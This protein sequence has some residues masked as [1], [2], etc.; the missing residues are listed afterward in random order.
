MFTKRLIQALRAIRDSTGDLAVVI[1]GASVVMAIRVGG[2]ALTYL[3]HV[4]IARWAGPFEFGIFA[5]AWVWATVL[6]FLAPLGLNVGAVRFIPDYLAH[7]RWSLVAGMIRRS[8]SLVSGSGLILSGLAC[9]TVFLS[10]EW[11][12]EYYIIPLYI[13]F[14]CVP[15]F[16]L[17]DLYA[18]MA[19]S[20]EWPK[21]AFMPSY[22][23]RPALLAVAVGIVFYLGEALTATTVI[24]MALL[25]CLLTFF[26]QC[27]V[28]DRRVAKIIPRAQPDY[29][30]RHWLNVS[31][32]L[33]L[34]EGFYLVL[35]NTDII[36][37]GKY[38]A[39]D[40]V[41]IYY[42]AVKT[43]NLLTFIFFAVSALAAPRFSALYAQNKRQELHELFIGTVQWTF[44]PSLIVGFFLLA[45]GKPI[46]ALFGP[47]FVDGYIVLMVLVAAV[48]F[49]AAAGPLS[50]LLNM[51]GH[52]VACAWIVGA[53]AVLN[54]VF[55]ATLI[56]SFGLSGAAIA[57]T[58]SVV[59]S[60]IGLATL[61]KIRLDVSTLDLL[62][63]QTSKA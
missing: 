27:V 33:L 42:A 13:A 5:Y 55:N 15:L 4:L 2:A 54:I 16:G 31:F 10:K 38:V 21:L 59:L 62:R 9:L 32:P 52:Q 46:L 39:P 20:F 30:T 40:E 50:F 56:P 35:A 45:I 6:G 37:L 7:K 41:A 23:L 58:S 17:T 43:S 1:R 11:I 3:S 61:V 26:L 34:V 36:M 60:T 51:T 12:D 24:G 57:T 14:A 25:S 44:W 53:S 8:R 18:D 19:R 49:Q 63:R 47:T 29:L 28:F 22:V 48:L